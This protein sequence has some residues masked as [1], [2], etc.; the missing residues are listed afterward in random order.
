MARI[1][2]GDAPGEPDGADPRPGRFP[3]A[4]WLFVDGNRLVVTGLFVLVTYLVLVGVSTVIG[5]LRREETS[6]MFYLFSALAGGNFTLVTIVISVSQLVVSRQLGT[7][8]EIRERIDV[9]NDFREDVART[10]DVDVAP[11]TPTGFLHH[12]LE[13]AGSVVGSVRRDARGREGEGWEELREATDRLSAHLDRVS[14]NLAR[15]DV[16]LASALAVTLETNYSADIYRLEAVRTTYGERYPAPLRDSLDMLA[17]RLRQIDVG[18]QYLKNLYVQDELSKLS[19]NLLYVGVP[20]VL[21]S[22]VMLRG[23]AV[24]FETI[25]PDVLFAFVPVGITVAL[26]PLVMLFAYVLRIATVTRHTMAITP[27]TMDVRERDRT[28]FDED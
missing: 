25:S 23:F 14:S 20:A 13:S 22:V 11:V 18:R 2:D 27:F 10:S 28:S 6:P 26:A 5:P 7:P 9:S 16:S 8:G 19:L 4:S 15:G 21:S 17:V 3:R 12:L 24:G 1:G